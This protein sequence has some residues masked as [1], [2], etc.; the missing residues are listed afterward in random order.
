[1]SAF[2]PITPLKA[3][4]LVEAAGVPGGRR[5]IADFSAAGL[6]K[7]YALTIETIPVGG[8]V[9]CI[10]DSAVSVELWKRIIRESVVD[11]VWTGG[12]VTLRP[13]D[14]VGGE[15]EVRI[16]GIRFNTKYLQRLVDHHRDAIPTVLP[17]SKVKAKPVGEEQEP[18]AAAHPLKIAA[19]S[20][21]GI[22]EGAL[23]AS[24][25]QAM[26]ALGIGKTKLYELMDRGTLRSNKLGRSR[27]IDVASIH[28]LLGITSP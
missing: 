8:S 1:M 9:T 27:R 10:R 22:P 18:P 16:T 15:P 21:A 5:L 4:E 6:I 12:T 2:Q 19:A 7:S 11:D 14:L 3:I 25:E 23:Q 20:S 28:A 13:A 17:D 26:T 24:P